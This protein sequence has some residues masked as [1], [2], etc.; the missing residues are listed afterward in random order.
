MSNKAYRWV[1]VVLWMIVIFAFSA[2]PHSGAVTEKY[3][4][5]ANVPIRKAAHMTEYAIL[6]SLC[7]WAALG[8]VNGLILRR[9]APLLISA[10]YACSDEFHQNFVPGRS[11]TASDVLVDCS[12][13]SLAWL[14]ILAWQKVSVVRKQK[15]SGPGLD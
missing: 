1:L 8:T 15:I 7:R 4:G 9:W 10:L 14:L 6:F 13:A 2:Q 3:F 5:A 11:A 12:G